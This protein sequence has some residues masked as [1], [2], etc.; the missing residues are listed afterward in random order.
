MSATCM[1]GLRPQTRF[2][3]TN[4][5]YRMVPTP[6]CFTRLANIKRINV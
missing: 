4:L 1:R 2:N 5:V 6:R 3:Q